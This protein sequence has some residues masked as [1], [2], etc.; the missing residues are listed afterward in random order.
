MPMHTKTRDTLYQ[1]V[2]KVTHEYFG[3]AADRFVAR[4]IRNHLNKNPK[5]LRKKD[6]ARLINWI[7]VAMALLHED[8]EQ[9]HKYAADLQALTTEK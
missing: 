9:I 8:E 6:L 5:E 7:S 2:V 4:Q 1:Q 3:P